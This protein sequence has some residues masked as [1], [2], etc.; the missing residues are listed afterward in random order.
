MRWLQL[1]Q[2]AWGQSWQHS[3]EQQRQQLCDVR[4]LPQKLQRQLLFRAADHISECQ[5]TVASRATA[6]CRGGRCCVQQQQQQRCNETAELCWCVV[7][8]GVCA[9]AREHWTHTCWMGHSAAATDDNTWR[10]EHDTGRRT[11]AV[12][13]YGLCGMLWGAHAFSWDAPI[14]AYVAYLCSCP[15]L[16]LLWCSCM[17]SFAWLA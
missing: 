1:T 13:V 8:T 6:K 9:S 10:A 16:Y 14:R 2:L 17:C 3:R 7:A 12:S 5:A 4:A 11:R 15:Q